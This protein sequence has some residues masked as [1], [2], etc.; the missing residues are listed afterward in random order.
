METLRANTL[1][2]QV[3]GDGM[4]LYRSSLAPRSP[5]VSGDFDALEAAVEEGHR[6]GI[7]VHAYMNVC[8]VWSGGLGLPSS[9]A[10]LLRAHPEWAVVDSEGRSDLEFAQS[11][12]SFVFFC[13]EWQGFRDHCVGIALELATGYD[14]DGLHLD[15]LRFPVGLPR[16]FCEEHRRSFAAAFGRLPADGDP[17]FIEWRY[18]TITRLFAEIYDAVTALRPGIKVS[19]ALLTPTGRYYQDGKRILEAGKLDI[20]VP[21]IYTSDVALFTREARYFHENSGGRLVY[22][23]LLADGGQ[24]AAEVGAA[25]AVGLEGHVLFSWSTLDGMGRGDIALVDAAAEPP[26][27]MPWKDGSI[28]D[29][30][31]V[32]S[33]LEVA[34]ILSGE[35]TVRWH[36]DERASASV[37]YGLTSA[38]G[39]RAEL[40]HVLFDH[41][42][43]LEGLS[44]STTYRFRAVAHDRAGTITRSDLGMFTTREPG[45]VEVIVDDGGA[46]FTRGGSWSAGSSAGGFEGDYVFA[47]DQPVATA[48]AEFRPF[49][50][51]AG[52]YE[53]AVWYVAG[54][55]RVA[56]APYTVVD[57]GGNVTFRVDQKAAGGR[58]NVLGSFRFREGATGYVRLTNQAAGGDVVIADAVRFL[59]ERVEPPFLRGDADGDGLI[60]ISDPLGILFSVFLD[61]P[62]AGCPDALDADDSGVIQVTDAIQLLGYLFRRGPPPRPPFPVPGEDPTEDGLGECP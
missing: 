6:R 50:P 46:G 29:V 40:P 45:P 22:A 60:D 37:E 27:P 55:N 54:A 61:G 28:D 42:V 5:L 52:R 20:A 49:L 9:P 57:A 44:A 34:G 8:N 23:G 33:G 26:P 21:M 62:T 51:R 43:R 53:V 19:A 36:T 1:L 10:H 59:L 39:Q 41:A 58:W 48:W 15:Y 35:A 16:C 56:D 11:P 12:G 17:D 18:N 13:P 24:V 30:A 25:R 3:Y 31:P 32:L 4:A 2:V 47:S 38:L 7:E 14:I